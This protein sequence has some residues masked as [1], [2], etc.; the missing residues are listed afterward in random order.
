MKTKPNLKD[1]IRYIGANEN[2]CRQVIILNLL[3]HL[4]YF[5]L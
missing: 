3:L 2:I 4:S 1:L 5:L